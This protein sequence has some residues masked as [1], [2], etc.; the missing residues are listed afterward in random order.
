MAI[1][2]AV[3]IGGRNHDTEQK[4]NVADDEGGKRVR[5]I[6]RVLKEPLDSTKSR[7]TLGCCSCHIVVKIIISFVSTQEHGV[8]SYCYSGNYCDR[9]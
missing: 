5:P 7:K 1:T 3:G 6:G 8:S 4:W 2:L 9:L